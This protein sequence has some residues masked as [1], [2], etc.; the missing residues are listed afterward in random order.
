MLNQPMTPF[1]TAYVAGWSVFSLVALVV[2]IRCVRVNLAD[3]WAFLRMPWKV[4]LFVPA[5][6]FVTF[7]GRFT[8]DETW[9]VISGGG[10]S[11]FTVATAWWAVGTM[12]R[13]VRRERPLR[14]LLVA[15]GVTFFS[16]S[17]FYDGYLLLRDGRCV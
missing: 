9:D 10:M 17:W 14:E 16:S 7:A 12:V 1:L 4:A 3:A 11:V 2:G 6:V 13:V 8:D 15:I 5:F